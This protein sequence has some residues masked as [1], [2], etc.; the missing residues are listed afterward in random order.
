M[1]LSQV[2]G[3]SWRE[4]E[5]LIIAQQENG[6]PFTAFPTPLSQGIE[7]TRGTCLYIIMDHIIQPYTLQH[8]G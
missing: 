8:Q 1:S 6:L 2:N 4:G 5:G 3:G 7:V